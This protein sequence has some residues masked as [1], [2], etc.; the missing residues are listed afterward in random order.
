MPMANNVITRTNTFLL[1]ILACLLTTS[2]WAGD[3]N[4]D[5]WRSLESKN[6][7]AFKKAVKEGADVNSINPSGLPA[8]YSAVVMKRADFVKMLIEADANVNARV[9]YD[10]TTMIPGDSP[11]K[12]AAETGQIEIV[13]LL[14]A[15]KADVNAK[16]TGTEI[17]PLFAASCNGRSAVVKLLLAANADVNSQDLFGSSALICASQ[18]GHREV[19]RLLLKAKADTAL[20]DRDDKTALQHALDEGN[21]AIAKML[22]AA[23]AT[24]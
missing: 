6:V 5:L 4:T 15:A 20:K 18:R 16:L 9:R 21:T 19:G 17:T 7:A 3:P 8:I 12:Y 23:G 24:E 22:K 11:L 14:L 10:S 2:L 1:G 13:K